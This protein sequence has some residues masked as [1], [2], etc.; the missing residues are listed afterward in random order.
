LELDATHLETLRAWHN[1]LAK[2]HGRKVKAIRRK[3]MKMPVQ[4]GLEEFE[5]SEEEKA[6]CAAEAHE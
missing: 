2:R 5:L 1:Q 3:L 6:E 4:R